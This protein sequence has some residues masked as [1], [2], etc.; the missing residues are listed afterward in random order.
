M[1]K[2]WW[3]QKNDIRFK[4]GEKS[5]LIPDLVFKHVITIKSN[6]VVILSL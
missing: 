4:E 6:E 1:K 5:T 2:S 3:T